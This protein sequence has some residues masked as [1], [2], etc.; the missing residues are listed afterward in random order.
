MSPHNF[1]CPGWGDQGVTV[2]VPPL[3][4]TKQRIQF[5]EAISHPEAFQGTGVQLPRRP[6]E[7][8]IEPSLS[9]DTF[10][11]IA[12][13]ML[14]QRAL[15]PHRAIGL[16]ATRLFFFLFSCF[17]MLYKYYIIIIYVNLIIIQL[18]I[19][20]SNFVHFISP[21]KRPIIV[22]DVSRSAA[23]L[24]QT[25]GGVFACFKTEHFQSTNLNCVPTTFHYLFI[26]SKC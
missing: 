21:R 5:L 22:C 8:S 9:L 2:P 14:L 19:R 17:L 3:N 16:E 15:P 13:R 6:Y 1:W 4:C 24:P 11:R 10:V 25:W 7:P 12:P 20:T 18:C 23:V 26:S